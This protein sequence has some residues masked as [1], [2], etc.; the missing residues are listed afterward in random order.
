MKKMQCE[1]CGGKEIRKVSDGIFECQN[2]GTQYSTTEIKNLMVEVT[3]TVKIDHSEDVE[4]AV[5]RA[6]QCLAQGDLSKA[7]EYY[8]IALDLDPDNGDIAD[9]I[10]SINKK[11]FQT[12]NMHILE[13]TIS[14][15]KAFVS[16][17]KNFKSLK[18]AAPDIYKEIEIISKSEAYYPFAIMYGSYYGSYSGTACFRKQ[19]PVPVEKIKEEF[20][21]GER[22]KVK[23]TEIE[24]RTEIDKKPASGT[25]TTDWREVFSLSASLFNS[26]S[27]LCKSKLQKDFSFVSELESYFDDTYRDY[28][29]SVQTLDLD[30]ISPDLPLSDE[31]I[32][33]KLL[34]R[35]KKLYK[36]RVDRACY[37]TARKSVGGD[38][39][40]NVRYDWSTR[41]QSVYYLYIPIQVVEY[42]YKG[43]FYIAVTALVEGCKKHNL[44]YPYYETIDSVAKEGSQEVNKTRHKGMYGFW[45]WFAAAVMGIF[46][47]LTSPADG[48]SIS[49]ICYTIAIGF[50][51]LGVLQTTLGLIKTAQAN[52]LQREYQQ[53]TDKLEQE[54][55]DELNKEFQLFFNHYKGVDSIKQCTEVVRKSSSFSCKDEEISCHTP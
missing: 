33:E 39:T 55:D 46:G 48:G 3:G 54:K 45:A 49:G 11:R 37:S 10:A 15:E 41:S 5:K 31:N 47:W 50:V 26:C 34:N 21:N 8:N 20:V 14:P 44:I 51:I 29:D 17:L 42:A 28:L 2:C 25:Y 53:K 27:G 32:E 16:F 1:V 19:V 36:D 35:A 12:P 4:N 18:N 22:R 38:S 9:K 23:V 6:E 43:D 7:L 24:Y 40:E 30:K 52:K 13:R